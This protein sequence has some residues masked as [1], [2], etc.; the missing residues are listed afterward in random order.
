MNYLAPHHFF[1]K[2]SSM[3]ILRALP[4]NDKHSYANY[5]AQTYYYVNHS[6]RLLALAA[7]RLGNEDD[8]MQRRFFKH[9]SEES[10]HDKLLLN[11]LK[12]LG[13]QLEDF[14]EASETKM[15]WET[16]YYKI[17]H[18]DPAALLG[19][20]Y[21]LEDLACSICP[22]LTKLLTELYGK[23][24]V[25]FLKLHGEEDPD[26]VTKAY[27]QIKK[28]SPERQR[29]ITLNYEQSA[30]AYHQVIAACI[31]GETSLDAVA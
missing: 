20:I 16:Q 3:T 13:F 21:F 14:P 23:K 19:Y 1:L 4:W 17:E 10:A 12:S 5:L 28:L 11:D 31:R 15:F 6:E 27:E 29:I 7:A 26:H 18:Q 8:L 9:L 30:I 2:D 22:E 24:C 25:S